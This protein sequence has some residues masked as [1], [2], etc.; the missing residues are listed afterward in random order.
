MCLD[1]RN[2]LQ[3]QIRM[4]HL[5]NK[6]LQNAINEEKAKEYYGSILIYPKKFMNSMALDALLVALKNDY[7]FYKIMDCIKAMP[8]IKEC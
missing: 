1:V 4:V 7:E 2:E 8:K 6:L 5:M 3:K